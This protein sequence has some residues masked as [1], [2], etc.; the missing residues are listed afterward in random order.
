MPSRRSR[1]SLAK[2]GRRLRSALF[3]FV[4]ASVTT[5]FT[6]KCSLTIIRWLGFRSAPF[7]VYESQLIN[8]DW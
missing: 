4:V 3:F 2:K 8:R 1:F 6:P 7:F 5:F